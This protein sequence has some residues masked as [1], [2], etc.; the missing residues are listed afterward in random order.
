MGEWG[1]GS[2]PR[3]PRAVGLKV[4]M[5]MGPQDVLKAVAAGQVT[6]TIPR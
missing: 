1:R 3:R 5:D 2:V 4:D 6:S